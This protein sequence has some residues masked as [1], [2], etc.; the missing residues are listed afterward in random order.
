[1]LGDALFSDI[2]GARN[3]RLTPALVMTGVT[4]PEILEQTPRADVPELVFD[5][6]GSAE[7][8]K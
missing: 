8:N 3:A 2:A 1:M 5:T 7:P 6:I 4:T